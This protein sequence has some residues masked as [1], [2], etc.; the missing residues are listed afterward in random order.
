MPESDPTKVLVYQY[1]YWDEQEKR[2][3]DSHVSAT[4]I[5]IRNGLGMPLLDTGK[6]V[7]QAEVEG[8]IYCGRPTDKK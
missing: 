8:G 4:I 5:A 1:R 7:P 2:F 3:K 6:W